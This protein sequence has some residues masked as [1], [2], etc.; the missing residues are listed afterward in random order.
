MSAL[1]EVR[2]ISGKVSQNE[3]KLA[4][5][6]L[7]HRNRIAPSCSKVYRTEQCF[8]IGDRLDMFNEQLIVGIILAIAI[9][10]SPPLVPDVHYT[11][12]LCLAD[13]SLNSVKKSNREIR[14][15]CVFPLGEMA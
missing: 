13:N 9:P 15:V 10:V 7:T 8:D 6:R 4:W 3:R 5:C 14:Y 2:M 1:A 11:R 12:F